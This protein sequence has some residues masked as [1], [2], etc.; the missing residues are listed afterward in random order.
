[1]EKIE[2]KIGKIRKKI[3]RKRSREY[4]KV[5]EQSSTRGIEE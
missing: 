3:S 5:K 1:M 2:S 4:E